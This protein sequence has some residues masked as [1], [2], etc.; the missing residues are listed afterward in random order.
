MA[1][2]WPGVIVGEDSLARTVS[3]LRQALGDDAKAPRYIETIAK[4]GYRLLVEVESVVSSNAPAP[5]D[6]PATPTPASS[7]L[8][9]DAPAPPATSLT[10]A[11]ESAPSAS[12][13]HLHR[14]VAVIVALA[15]LAL[16]ALLVF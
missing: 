15:L 9:M 7:T 5:V 3:K 6:L 10:P 13:K 11:P 8:S 4:R 14:T 2:L 1:A 16:L 12:P